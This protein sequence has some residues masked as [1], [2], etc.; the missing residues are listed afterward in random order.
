[1]EFG[2]FTG[3]PLYRISKDIKGIVCKCC[4]IKKPHSYFESKDSDNLSK[5]YSNT[6]NGC[7]KK[8]LTKNDESKKYILYL[9]P[10]ITN[11]LYIELEK[12]WTN[13]K[14]KDISNS[15]LEYPFHMTLTSFFSA[16]YIDNILSKINEKLDI[17]RGSKKDSFILKFNRVDGNNS[18]R[19][20]Y[21][22]PGKEM[23]EFLES[24][25]DIEEIHKPITTDLHF[26]LYNKVPL[27]GREWYRK[28][29]ENISLT[30]TDD[31]WHIIL[32]KKSKNGFKIVK[33][34]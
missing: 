4:N 26:T 23:Q 27:N 14:N 33:R 13:A 8:Y 15:A 32:W 2:I 9:H 18:F 24:L 21:M 1:M 11:P 7:M 6:C 25:K 5:M 16:K 28:E 30:N 10:S 22:E 3:S 29:V 17:I 20:I 31:N 12:Y 19:A 34:F